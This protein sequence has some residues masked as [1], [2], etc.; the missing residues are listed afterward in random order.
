MLRSLARR[1]LSVLGLG[2]AAV[3]ALSAMTLVAYS[4]VELARFKRAETQRAVV[5]ESAG[6]V[7]E[8]GVSVRAIDLA[9]TLARLGYAET[10][11]APTARGQFRRG[12]ESWDIRL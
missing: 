3:A 12:V 11:A 4:T 9:N 7:L 1:K 8:P 2:V 5:I 10:K 6:Q